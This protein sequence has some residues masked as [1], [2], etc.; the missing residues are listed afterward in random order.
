[1]WE[2]PI[3]LY[4]EVTHQDTLLQQKPKPT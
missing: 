4:T 2:P 3:I 1:M